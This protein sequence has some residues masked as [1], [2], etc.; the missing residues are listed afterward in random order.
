MRD[1]AL[2]L[3]A[4]RPCTRLAA[5]SSHCLLR[6]F[7]PVCLRPTRLWSGRGSRRQ[8]G[9]RYCTNDLDALG[10][11]CS[12]LPGSMAG[13][14][15]ALSR[16][17]MLPHPRTAP[18]AILEPERPR[19]RLVL[20][21]TPPSC[22]TTPLPSP[23]APLGPFWFSPWGLSALVPAARLLR[24]ACS[25]VLGSPRGPCSGWLVVGVVS[26]LWGCWCGRCSAVRGCVA[27][28]SVKRIILCVVVARGPGR[29][30]PGR[31][32]EAGRWAREPSGWH[33]PAGGVIRSGG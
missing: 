5:F 12:A 30:P 27:G 14:M 2:A 8:G 16:A 18:P 33:W 26:R 23:S 9:A 31:R 20:T 29:R 22:V 25:G 3:A 6:G 1:G 17:T 21:R 19:R 24:L 4:D 7:H 28:Q 10:R 15:E 11:G 13:G 32:Q